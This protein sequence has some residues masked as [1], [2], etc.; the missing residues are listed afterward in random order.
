MILSKSTFNP[1]ERKVFISK[2]LNLFLMSDWIRLVIII[3]GYLLLR[4][5]LVRYGAKLQQ[6]QLEREDT[7][8]AKEG[9]L[10]EKKRDKKARDTLQWGTGARIRQ[11]HATEGL[12]RDREDSDSDELEELLEK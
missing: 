4:P 8:V 10:E 12:I 7:K 2:V 5:I 11:R 3:G 9:K 1:T 6:Q